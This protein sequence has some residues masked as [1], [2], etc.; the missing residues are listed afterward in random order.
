MVDR[1]NGKPAV[2]GFEVLRKF[3]DGEIDLR[4]TPLTGRS[5]QIRVHAAHS[6]GLG[7]PIKGDKLYGAPEAG[8]LFL[9]AESLTFRHPESG[10]KLSFETGSH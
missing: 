6:Q 9:F 7:R 2:T 4:F 5:H 10:E 1:E 3:P 8:R